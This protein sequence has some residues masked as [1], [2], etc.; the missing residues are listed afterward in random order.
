MDKG[1]TPEERLLR[2]IKDGPKVAKKA[3]PAKQPVSAQAGPP[4]ESAAGSVSR[5]ADVK[6]SFAQSLRGWLPSVRQRLKFNI[7]KM[8]KVL[9]ALFLIVFIYTIYDLGVFVMPHLATMTVKE[10]IDVIGEEKISSAEKDSRQEKDYQPLAYYMQEIEKRDL[11][12][13]VIAER[14]DQ[15]Q[16]Q[17]ARLKLDE[18]AKTFAL[19]G[20]VAGEAPQAVIEDTK[21]G[22]TYFVTKGENIGE[23]TIEEI[24][25]SKVKIKF[26]DQTI[27]LV[28]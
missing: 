14:T 15:A 8:N 1:L 3:E 6:R 24:S 23:I 21:A 19:K 17:P 5:Q 13:S 11:F 7:V 22:K 4:E 10:N 20:I 18:I 25:G 9:L 16:V 12:K 28:L 26:G 27:E 2:L